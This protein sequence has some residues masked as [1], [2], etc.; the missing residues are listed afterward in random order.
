MSIELADVRAR[1]QNQRQT[2][3]RAE[4]NH[5]DEELARVL[6][7]AEHHPIISGI[8]N[9]LRI[10][11][12]YMDFDVETWIRE[13][14][15]ARATN[16]G[17]SLDDVSRCAQSLKLLEWAVTKINNNSNILFQLGSTTY[18]GTSSELIDFIHSALDNLFEPLYLYVDNEL[19]SMGSLITPVDMLHDI[20]TIVDASTS[21]RFPET[22]RLLT[23]T[24]K[25]L[26]TLTANS[27]G[28]S[29]YLIGYSCRTV[30]IK[31]GNE[32]FRPHYVAEGQD[33]P[34]EDDANNKLKWTTR[35][36][37][38]A[39][40]TG[41]RYRESIEKIIQ[42]NWDYV[43]NIGH[44]QESV[45]ESDARLALIYSYLTISIISNIIGI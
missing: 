5:A 12:S 13:H 29:W 38:K 9:L 42:A 8:F 24:Y 39:L 2:L 37:L 19:R 45:S 36:C 21:M 43:N 25:Q 27:S 28:A 33:Q 7:F 20:Q 6:F 31:F 26:F 17:L 41:D 18:G 35:Y 11:S 44:R 10:N 15:K 22:H 30:L 14:E 16:L 4:Y 34:K 3:L 23:D 32:V 40:G 1:W